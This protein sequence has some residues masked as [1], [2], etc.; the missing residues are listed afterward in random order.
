MTETTTPGPRGRRLLPGQS[1]RVH[2]STADRDDVVFATSERLYEAPN[3]A[4]DGH[5]VLNGDGML[6]ELALDG[7]PK[8]RRL[9]TQGLPAVNNDH[10]LSP[11]GAT[12]YASADDGHIYAVP[13]AGGRARRITHDDGRLH[14]LHGVDPTGRRLAY[15][16]IDLA[17]PVAWI[18]HVRVVGVDGTGDHA[19]TEPGARHDDGPEYSPDGEWVLFNTERFT[20]A[21]GHAQ[22]ARVRGDGTGLERLA[23]TDLVDW[24]PH[25]APDG[26]RGV[27]LSFPLGTLGHPENLPVRLNLVDLPDWQHPWRTI[28]LFG[29]QG[30]INV[31][32]WAPDSTAFAWVDYPLDQAR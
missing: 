5:L 6:W 12:I 31:N 15:V 30:T 7:T 24:F 1:C 25:V 19:L 4:P 8:P 11:D 29:G 26:R 23:D 16:A 27:Y 32:S 3:W 20:T 9:D 13:R 14:F 17:E 10:L 22:L 21:A 2:V 28:D 18:G